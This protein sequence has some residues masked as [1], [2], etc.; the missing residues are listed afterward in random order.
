MFNEKNKKDSDNF[1]HRK[2]TLKVKFLHFL[3]ARHQSKTQNSIISYGYVDSFAKIFLI[4][5]PLLENS[6][7]RIATLDNR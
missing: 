6:T 5:Y 3:T 1:Q 4:L 7:T 2:L